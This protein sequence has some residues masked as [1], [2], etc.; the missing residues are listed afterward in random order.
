MGRKSPI[1][2]YPT[3]IWRPVGGDSVWNFVEI[4]G[5][6][7]LVSMDYPTTLFS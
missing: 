3:Y 7:K 5:I 4:C 1:L 2:I 6:K